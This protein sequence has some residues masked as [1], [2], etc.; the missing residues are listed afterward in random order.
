MKDVRIYE[1]EINNELKSIEVEVKKLSGS[2]MIHVP[3]YNIHGSIRDEDG[4]REMVQQCIDSHYRWQLIQ[5]MNNGMTEW[6][7]LPPVKLKYLEELRKK[8]KK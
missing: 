8:N 4:I 6:N 5:E 2:Y 7:G 3:E 1:I